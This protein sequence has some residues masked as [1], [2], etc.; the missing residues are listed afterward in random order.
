MDKNVFFPCSLDIL[1]F[2]WKSC[3]IRIYGEIGMGNIGQRIKRYAVLIFTAAALALAGGLS[4]L[5]G[6]GTPVSAA[7]DAARNANLVVRY[8]L[9]E[10]ATGSG[11][12]L[13][14][15][16]WD[17]ASQ[18][19][20]ANTAFNAT[21]SNNVNGNNAGVV[22]S[23]TA[24]K[25]GTALSFTGKAHARANF[26]LPEGAT[27]MTVSLWVKNIT[28]YWGSLVEFWDGTNGAEHSQNGGRFGKGTMQSNGG[29][30]NEGDPWTAN[31]SAHSDATMALGGGWDSFIVTHNNT[32]NDNGGAAVDNMKADTWYQVTFT[33]DAN[34][35]KAYRDGVL[36]Q[37]FANDNAKD[38]VQSILK[39]A[40]NQTAGK[41]GIRLSHDTTDNRADVIDELR[42]Y[43]GAMTEEE[44][45]GLYFEYD[46]VAELR[47]LFPERYPATGLSYPQEMLFGGAAQVT[48]A[49]GKKTG[50]TSNGVKYSYTPLTG[51]ATFER[52]AQGITVDLEKEG[53]TAQ[54]TVKFDRTLG[55][56][57]AFNYK[58]GESGTDVPI[59]LSGAKDG[60][61]VVKVPAGTDFA[62]I[63]AGTIS[64][65]KFTEDGADANYETMFTYN[66]ASHTAS[67]RCTY[68]PLRGLDTYYTFLFE[69]KN[70]A[71]F[72]S[73]RID[74]GKGELVLTPADFTQNS[75]NVP[76][77]DASNFTISVGL[78]LA[79]G[80]K[81]EGAKAQ[82]TQADLT[83]GKISIAV[84]N[85][86]GDVSVYSLV[87]VAASSD[88]SLTA[89]TV[90]GYE[91]SPAFNSATKAYSVT[92]DKGEGAKLLA[93]VSATPAAGATVQKMYNAT[94]GK[95]VISVTAAD[96][97]V[98]EYVITVTEKDTDAT[99][100]ELKAGDTAVEGFDP[101]VY[102]Y[103]VKYKGEMP[104]VSAV[105][106]SGK[107]NVAVGEATAEGKVTVTVT[108]E[109]GA[110][111]TYTVT[112][113]K[114]SSDASVKKLTV[115]GTE[116]ALEGGAG[117]YRAPYGGTADLRVEA[118]VAEG[119]SY[120]CA[121]AEDGSK[122]EVTVTAE[123][124]TEEVYTVTLKAGGA[125]F[126][127]GTSE[128]NTPEAGGCNA[129]IGAAGAGIAIAVVA[130]AAL[131][132][133]KKRKTR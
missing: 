51:T 19:F 14:A 36:K 120:T 63:K 100:K 24:G 121:V 109:S 29:R 47:Y 122:L 48:D 85:E 112:L 55:L 78:T 110:T 35:M 74:G 98:S 53:Y 116:I 73:M 28:T 38:I 12:T 54:K 26:H 68:V 32:N 87:P 124:G 25:N 89:L 21:I 42:I 11:A 79:D 57:A 71:T 33:L 69:E 125:T 94:E 16:R 133:S 13:A 117:E 10:T 101:A 106:A 59:D 96:G 84:T 44:V 41:L 72:T 115:N 49:G 128:D 108:A 132:L 43:N 70:T 86:N 95:L 6:K 92:I 91:L 127:D 5:A 103:T 23:V 20:V 130:G 58:I 80:A 39:A 126:A 107:A 82:Y 88:A 27:G 105:A 61:I 46:P 34:G 62:Q 60:H 123:D 131:L 83:G 7:T 65:N 129:A 37:T 81:A 102:A 45:L 40:T 118:E 93:A 9:D 75:V 77:A 2:L 66:A 50:V 17:A 56:T 111:L 52:D 4:L 97:S 3:V 114:M 104:A 8:A 90:T 113:V 119:A 22:S 30:V 15:T 64:V 67:L 31:C 1:L 76:V 99:L 18:A